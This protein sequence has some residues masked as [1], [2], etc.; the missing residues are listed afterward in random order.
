[1][2]AQYSISLTFF[3]QTFLFQKKKKNYSSFHYFVCFVH[4][5][6]LNA[7][8]ARLS[9]VSQNYNPILFI[10]EVF[11]ILVG[12][13]EIWINVRYRDISIYIIS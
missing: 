13:G 6:I 7:F 2:N 3:L 8:Q 11:E 1:M 12:L 5:N 9:G 10:L 4:D